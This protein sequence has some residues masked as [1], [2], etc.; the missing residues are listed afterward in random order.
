MHRVVPELILENF[1]AGKY[2]GE[3][4]AVGMFLDL[5]GFSKMTDTLMEHGQHGAEVLAGLMHSV[6]DPLVKSVFEHGGRIVS[7]AGDGIMA[8]YPIVQDERRTA[9]RALASAWEVQQAL[10][11]N[12]DRSTVYGVFSFSVKIGIA[13]GVV[14]WRILRSPDGKQAMY[15]FRGSAVNDAAAAEHYAAAREILITES[16]KDLL[17]NAIAAQ[18]HGPF[19]CFNGFHEPAPPPEAYSLPSVDVETSRLFVPEEVIVHDIRGE[20]RQIVNLF[21][22]LPDLPDEKL[23]DFAEAIFDLRAKY[24]GLLSRL[25]FGDKGC[26]MLLLWGAPVAYENDI[27]R[28]LN[29]VLDLQSRV[30]FPIT[31]GVTYYIAHAGYL[32]SEMCEDYTCY[33]WGINLASRFMVG[34]PDGAVWVDERVARRVSQR[35]EIEYLGSQSFK[36]FASEQKVYLLRRRKQEIKVI[37]QGEMVG[38]EQELNRLHRFVEPLWAGRFAG[39]LG[40]AGEAGI[41]KSRLLQEFYASRPFDQRKVGWG[42]G[43]AD[44][45]LRHSFNPL[46]GWL[47]NYFGILQDQSPEEQRL[48][49]HSRLDDLLASLPDL[50]LARELD[51]TRSFLAALVDIFEDDTLYSHLDAEGRYNNTLLALI[52]LIKAECLRQ[53]FILIV[54]DLHFA[55]QDTLEFL[56][57]LKRSLVAEA[58]TCPVAVILSYRQQGIDTSAVGSLV[59]D[60]ITLTS[61]SAEGIA[62]I[63][64]NLLGGTAAPDLIALI[65]NRSEGNPYF[66]EQIVRYLQEENLLEVGPEGWRQVRR[67]LSSELPSDIRALLVARI[68]QL[69]RE[70]RN[71]VQAASV[72]GREFDVRVL[73]HMLGTQADVFR[74]VPEAEKTAIWLPLQESRYLFYHGLLRDAAYSMQIRARRQEL[75]AAA[76]RALETIFAENLVSHYPELAYHAEQGNLPSEAQKYYTLAAKVSTASY[77]N[78]QAVEYFTRAL[79]YTPF[80]DLPTRFDLTAERVELYS[81]LGKRDLQLKDLNVLE[82]WAVQMQ[83]DLRLVKVAMFR[84]AYHYFMGNYLEAVEFAKRAQNAP[85]ELANSSLG[86]YATTAW[87][88]ALLRLG[89]LEEAMQIAKSVLTRVQTLKNRS[90]ECRIF[91]TMGWIAMEQRA[92]P[93]ARIYLTTA[94]EIARLYKR[95][96][97]EANALNNLAVLEGF[98]NGN[99]A[100][101]RQY[102]EQAL[103]AA[104]EIGNHIIIAST[105]ANIG[106]VTGMQGDFNSA[107]SY[108]RQSLATARECGSLYQ[109]IYTLINLSALDCIQ[110]DAETARRNA[111]RAAELARKSSERSGEAWAML[112]LGHAHLLQGEFESARKAFRASIQI[113][114]EINQ[115]VL[116]LE[117][118]AGLLAVCLA[119]NNLTAASEYAEPILNFL[120]EGNTLEGVEEPV[121]I[122]Y[123]CYLYLQRKDDPRAEQIL[124]QGCRLLEDQASKFSDETERWRYIENIPWRRAVW[125]AAHAK[126]KQG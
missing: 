106:Y 74:Y 8:L 46:R 81:R 69:P 21:M 91:N 38:R 44:Q 80:D 28:A 42:I 45:V 86:I 4:P 107:R 118:L 39:F 88:T 121:R 36:G 124:Q 109:E 66:A 85:E 90:E 1:R 112:Y 34:A 82:Q 122:Y 71:V 52:T 95:M 5:S 77:Q 50:S 7:F 12:P 123:T 65:M 59:D 55:D 102:H 101:A 40:V 97:V 99:Y 29:F 14:K 10:L 53:P 23:A 26:N 103:K 27:G 111:E 33:G 60:E 17:G 76:L 117:P 72:L 68:D 32:G 67:K 96:D 78:T 87:A 61:I 43:A 15:Y 19:Y 125:E 31:A 70:I 92:L 113:R 119:E 64:E 9:L 62:R 120:A 41:G 110:Q 73:A 18:P 100:L 89:R 48:A 93:E 25:D 105:L 47:M 116:A 104:R 16:L 37:Y 79:A 63:V 51:R 58:E 2:Q 35:F 75:H 20:F 98:L 56:V 126:Q 114:E 22:R 84:T 24:G 49:F 13:P 94:L 108:Y 115:P 57:R 54:D 30:D 3:F 11:Q 6:F 83:D